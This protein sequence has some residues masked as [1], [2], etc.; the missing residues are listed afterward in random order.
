MYVRVP[1]RTEQEKYA[2]DF[3]DFQ[4]GRITAIDSLSQTLE[5]ELFQHHL[6]ESPVR[7]RVLVLQDRAHR[8]LIL[9]DSDCYHLPT[10][11]WGRILGV[12]N[13]AFPPNGYVHYFVQLGTSIQQ[14]PENELIV[15]AHRQDVDPID[16]LKRYELH[17]PTFRHHRDRF[18]RAFTQLR[19]ATE[20]LEV[21]VNTRVL[22]LAH[23]AE[24]ITRVLNDSSCRY[25]LADE[26]GL[27]KTIEACVIAKGLQ[28]RNPNLKSLLVVPSALIH[29]WR[30]ELDDKFWMPFETWS[31]GIAR[32]RTQPSLLIVTHHDL[33]QDEGLWRYVTAQ[34]WDLLMVDEAHHIRRFPHLYQR[35]LEI[36]AKCQHALILSATPIQHRSTEYL[37]LLRLMHP[38]RY[39]QLKEA[40]FKH[41]VANQ[42][43][44]YDVV[45][46]AEGNLVPQYFEIPE[47][48]G[49][50]QP[51]QPILAHDNFFIELLNDLK[52]TANDKQ[53]LELAKQMLIYLSENY[54]IERRVI[55]NRRAHIDK[56]LLPER[57]L[58]ED[59][60]YQPSEAEQNTLQDLLIY[61]QALTASGSEAAVALAEALLHSA[62]SSP[63]ALLDLVRRRMNA[64]FDPRQSMDELLY[65]TA[66]HLEPKRL[67]RLIQ[68]VPPIADEALLLRAV[69][70]HAEA[71][72][73][74]FEEAERLPNH[75]LQIES[76]HR[77]IQVLRAVKHITAK[78]QAKAVI[79]TSWSPTLQM[80][81]RFIGR[82]MGSNRIAQF[83]VGLNPDQ[84]Q[85]EVDRFQ[86]SD[87]CLIMLCDELGGEGRNFQI[88]SAVVHVDLPWSPA[89]I[90]QR[91]G[92]VD[93]LGRQG[94]VQSIVTYAKATQEEDLFTLMKEAF[95]LFSYSMSGLEIIIEE[96]HA[97]MRQTL[98]HDPSCGLRAA[99]P[100]IQ[101]YIN[102]MRR[103]IESERIFEEVGI[104]REKRREIEEI[105]AEYGDGDKL[106]ESICAWASQ[107]GMENSFNPHEKI[108]TFFPKRF[109]AASMANS[110]LVD[111]PNME[112]ALLRSGRRQNLVIQ[113]TFDRQIAV[114]REDL[115]FFAPN[116]DRWTQKIL[117]NAIESERGRTTSV[118]LRSDV[119][120][121]E[122]TGFEYL[123]TIQP[124][125]RPFLREG[126]STS[127]LYKAGGI[128]YDSTY[129]VIVDTQC[130]FLKPSHPLYRTLREVKLHQGE[131]LG[132]RDNKRIDRFKSIYPPDVWHAMVDDTSRLAWQMVRQAFQLD[133]E[134]EELAQKLRHEARTRQAVRQWLNA[135]G[136][137]PEPED[138]QFN[139]QIAAALVESIRH[140]LIRLESACFWKVVPPTHEQ[141]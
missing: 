139:H 54:R 87:E 79:F 73:E 33:A 102:R 88:A 28:Q 78:P 3:R 16:Q 34:R 47:F 46:A 80:L 81:L 100:Q 124:N 119:V 57:S 74:Q 92:R 11:V 27:G 60:A 135:Q 131:H 104:D 110:K 63:H 24:V 23:Q 15:G 65:P 55:R 9:S 84:L 53:G 107:A 69:Q 32:N 35:L 70:H 31:S 133:E 62:F 99:L 12:V 52:Q 97:Q 17:N 2:A 90:E 140:P 10:Q 127:Q 68:F 93:R 109:N 41:I 4:I 29:Q 126:L 141:P 75:Y 103:E 113:G 101:K 120:K 5:V 112:D 82:Y 7:L 49:M 111:I 59:Y 91:I 18:I 6:T 50:V 44:L 122:W 21:V 95:G 51:L 76:P 83:H 67:Q 1:T 64:Q 19:N 13:D 137:P 58:V 105:S 22:L 66:P 36:S 89:L 39:Q 130:E 48:L 26:V 85:N 42:K 37:D 98:K 134:A 118:L 129:R 132:K 114:R 20:G 38:Q 94:I 86:S 56:S 61:I 108:V 115:V 125:P 138:T 71:W 116:G 121:E 25:I 136:V 123:F 128:I 117:Q 106:R 14:I 72:Q 96:V 45:E 30:H 40:Q 8:C 77:L 43:K